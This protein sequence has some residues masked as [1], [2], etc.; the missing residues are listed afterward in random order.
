VELKLL[1]GRYHEKFREM[2]LGEVGLWE[3]VMESSKA[4][5]SKTVEFKELNERAVA[6]I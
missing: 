5:F 4:V 1:Q 2:K 3:E 6:A